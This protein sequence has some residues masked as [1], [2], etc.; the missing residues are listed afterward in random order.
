MPKVVRVKKLE[1]SILEFLATYK[2]ATYDLL[3]YADV[4]KHKSH[5]SSSM[6]RMV[7][8]G[9]I[10]KLNKTDTIDN[11]YFLTSKGSKWIYDTLEI[12]ANYPKASLE[13]MPTQMEHHLHCIKRLVDF[14][15]DYEVLR[16]ASYLDNGYKDHNGLMKKKTDIAGIEPD[17][18]L[19]IRDGQDIEWFL[20]E[21]EN[22]KTTAK[23]MEKLETHLQLMGSGAVQD[24]L[25]FENRGY[26]VLLECS[27]QS[28]I[29]R[30]LKMVSEHEI[31][32]QLKHNFL[33]YHNDMWVEYDKKQILLV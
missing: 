30:V 27:L 21:Y 3:V 6:S 12:E 15:R 25:G 7:K 29:G 33:F 28:T 16:H 19:G 32:S 14:R 26:R 24:S 20:Y 1:K 31:L 4:Y 2:F 13:V 18:I 9:H 11:V 8:A 10:K 5:L 23:V 17:L 22:T